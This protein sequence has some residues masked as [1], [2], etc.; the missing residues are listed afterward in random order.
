MPTYAIG[1]VQGCYDE[2]QNLL[3][4]INFDPDKDTLWFAGDLVNRGPRSLDTLRFIK[5]L[6]HVKIVLGNHDLHLLALHHGYSH[7]DHD[8]DDILDAPDRDSLIGWLS[9]QPLLYVSKEHNAALTHAGIYPLW[10]LEDAQR[11]AREVETLL[12]GDTQK[13]LIDNMYGNTPAVWSEDLTG[14]DRARF[15]INV[16]TRMRFCSAEGELELSTKGKPSEAPLGYAPWYTLPH[17]LPQDTRVLFGHWAALEG[18]VDTKTGVENRIALDTGCVW[19]NALTAL[20]I[21][22]DNVFSVPGI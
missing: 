2:L 20:R 10:S 22:D 5:Q 13:A 4:T 8:L 17:K 6:P 9:T 21:E 1:D 14:W 11:Y 7:D 18:E 3:S 16:F 12:Q 15:I 19:G